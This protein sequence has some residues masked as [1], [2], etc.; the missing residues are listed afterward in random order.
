MR[1]LN[2]VVVGAGAVG[3]GVASC[4]LR[5]G[6]R[7]RFVTRSAGRAALER[8]G[9]VRTGIFGEARFPPDAFSVCASLTEL[10][11]GP[12]DY[13]LVCTKSFASREVAQALAEAGDRVPET[14][15]IVLFQNGWGN[16]EIFAEHTAA[17]RVFN[18]RVITGFRRAEPNEVEITVHAD[19]IRIGSL[20]GAPGADVEPLCRAI[21]AGGVP[22][23]VADNIEG[24]L[25]A[26]MLYNCALNPLG[27]I[28]DVPY[29]ALGR[30]GPARRIM[31]AVVAEVFAVLEKSGH[32]THWHGPEAYLEAFYAS[33]LPPTARHES[34]MLLDLRGGRRT[35]VDA[36]NGAV[37]ALGERL[38][39]GTPVNQTLVQLIRAIESCRGTH[40]PAPEG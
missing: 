23:Q 28:L 11:P 3:L 19:A 14:A 15:R 25:W 29:G 8:G 34:S 20:F 1:T 2:V 32:R 24:D 13:V 38:G 6:Q 22:C 39:V 10:P 35:E 27:A 18:A 36:L 40:S 9:L 37:V 33:I 5:S 16:A 30:S 31:R 12:L 7:V 21:D 17:P 26:K 4:L